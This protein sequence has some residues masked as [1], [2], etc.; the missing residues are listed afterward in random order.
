MS[1][2]ENLQNLRKLKNMSQEE[3]AEK[4]NVTRQSVSKWESRNG[5]PEMEKIISICK[6]FDCS[7]DQLVK[8]K[9][10]E[11]LKSDK[12][13]Y[14]LIMTKAAKGT[15]FGFAIILLGVA[16]M[17]TILG[18]ASGEEM[19]KKYQLIGVI[20]FFIGIVF[21]IPLFIINGSIKEDFKKK[22][23]KIANI[24]SEEEIRRGN[25]KYIK[26]ISIGIGNIIIGVIIMLLL[27]GLNTFG[28][29]SILPTAILM[30]FIAIG[31]LILTYSS[32][33]KEKFNID[34]YNRENTEEYR[35][36]ENKI[37]KICG[38]IMLIATIIFLVGGFAF[39]MWKKL[40]FVYPVG[41][42]LC[43][44]VSIILMKDN[45]EN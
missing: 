14:D 38:V 24:Y 27:K 41:G 15:S 40:W 25:L 36:L 18:F 13:N 20:V 32:M 8:G 44:L 26:Y 7:M 42:I 3:L 11:D 9:I 45:G 28:E 29:E 23:R 34:K 5:Y 37:A 33:M 22:N 2:S 39:D 43:V 31:V 10:S 6:I 1:L 19:M 30:Y 17:L 21:A 12:N 35:K 4:L 16:I